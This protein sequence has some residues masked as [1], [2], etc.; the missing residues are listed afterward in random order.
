MLVIVFLQYQYLGII[1]I[2]NFWSHKFHGRSAHSIPASVIFWHFS[3]HCNFNSLFLILRSFSASSVVSSIGISYFGSAGRRTADGLGWN[4][5]S[6]VILSRAR[7][8]SFNWILHFS[9][10]IGGS[11]VGRSQ[12]GSI[13]NGVF[14]DSRADCA[15]S[16]RFTI[17]MNE[18]FRGTN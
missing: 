4:N 1:E 11:E 9:H 18:L 14:L 2:R 8:A 13:D 16:Y 15:M 17:C 6:I 12:N 7:I 3:S 5:V 10:L